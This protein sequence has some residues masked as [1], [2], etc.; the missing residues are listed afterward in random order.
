MSTDPDPMLSE[1]IDHHAAGRLEQAV[2]A[3]RRALARDP[4]L[5][6]AWL[7]LGVACEQLGRPQEAIPA[8]DS[9]A[10][11]DPASA[12]ILAN[13]GNALRL[14][15]RLE[16]AV[17]AYRRALVLDRDLAMAWNNMG[18]ALHALGRL[19]EAC[20][21]WREVLARYPEV[22][23]TRVNLAQTLQELRRDDEA[24]AEYRLVADKNPNN[25][26]AFVALGLLYADAERDQEATEMFERALALEPGSAVARLSF[27]SSLEA[28]GDAERAK[29]ERRA[30]LA[31]QRVFVEPC[32]GPDPR[33]TLLLLSV[34]GF[35]NLPADFFVDRRE[36]GRVV[37]YPEDHV[38]GG[39]DDLPP[40]D[41][42]FNLIAD[43][44]TAEHALE[45]ADRFLQRT[46][47]PF[48][49]DP[50]KVRRTRRHLIPD[51]LAGISNLNVPRTVA[52][53]RL[54]LLAGDLAY[55][56]PLLARPAG[57][58]GGENLE[59]LDDA[60]GLRR[61][62]EAMS[63]ADVYLTPYVDYRSADGLFRKYRILFIDRKIYPLHLCI[64]DK[65]K[66]HYYTSLMRDHQ[67]MRDAEAALLE[68]IGAAFSPTLQAAATSIA[69]RLDLDYAG[70]DCAVTQAGELLVFEANANML[71]H[72][73]DPIEMFPYKHQFVPRAREAFHA[74][75]ARRIAGG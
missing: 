7:N 3:Y 14:C 20:D 32:A 36:Y 24:A 5:A 65:W 75:V 61:Y 44:D 29:R 47:K 62:L 60:Q 18:S 26:L 31:V 64:D 56:Y 13:L 23:Q 50:A 55:S 35:G 52:A 46:T 19:A 25:P 11:L 4:A 68:D 34:A 74:M 39:L 48:L 63:G 15:G 16:P 37:V 67:W 71:A 10:A 2:E 53:R 57:S 8:Y 70:M 69:E 41:L 27:A 1:A 73:N 43:P 30:A 21:A 22:A 42:I 49:N 51:L 66:A 9:A 33:A 28:L 40:H 54:D 45:G 38:E 12:Q 59:K 58:H 6:V 17:E 72:L